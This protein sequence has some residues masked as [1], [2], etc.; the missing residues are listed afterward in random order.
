MGQKGIIR[1]LLKPGG[2]NLTLPSAE[3]VPSASDAPCY[4]TEKPTMDFMNGLLRDSK[5]MASYV[6]M[7]PLDFTTLKSKLEVEEGEYRNCL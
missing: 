1:D 2:P 7:K 4:K 3:E 5:E 6:K